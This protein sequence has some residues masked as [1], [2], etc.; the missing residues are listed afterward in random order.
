EVRAGALVAPFQVDDYG[1]WRL[2]E[3]LDD[4]DLTLRHVEEIGAFEVARP[5]WLP[6]TLV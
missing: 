5:R 6:R 1:R 4:I 2:L 3:G